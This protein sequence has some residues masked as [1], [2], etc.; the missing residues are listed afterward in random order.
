[1]RQAA[2]S[3]ASLNVVP[4]PWA[5]AKPTSEGTR[6]AWRGADSAALVEAAPLEIRARPADARPSPSRSP[7]P[8]R[9][10]PLRAGA[11]GPPPREEETPPLAQREAVARDVE[12]PGS[13]RDERAL[14][15]SP[16]KTKGEMASAPPARTQVARPSRIHSAARP[17]RG[18]ARR[19][20]RRKPSGEG[21]ARVRAVRRD[22]E[23]EHRDRS[24][25][26]PP[27]RRS[28]TRSH[29]VRAPFPASDVP[30]A[31]PARPPP[32]SGHDAS[33]SLAASRAGSVSRLR[34]VRPALAVDQGRQ[35]RVKSPGVETE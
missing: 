14:A 29:S 27:V 2:S 15:S 35:A 34:A 13:G 9:E 12:R 10:S 30:T 24:E 23:R 26:G 22:R 32:K 3:I 28:A 21:A 4:V 33:A 8:A 31:I 16:G 17:D 20:R 7:R 6:P 25:R 11:P 18:R 19:A 1:M 5:L